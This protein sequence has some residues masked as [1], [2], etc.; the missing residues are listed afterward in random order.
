MKKSAERAN[1]R[2]DYDNARE[3][4]L[5]AVRL[6]YKEKID[7]ALKILREERKKLPNTKT[8]VG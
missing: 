1:A 7:E 3:N 5:E 6:G 2:T 8:A 4:Y